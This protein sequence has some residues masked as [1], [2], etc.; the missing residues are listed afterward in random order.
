MLTEKLQRASHSR[1]HTLDGDAE[2]CGNLAVRQT[3]DAVHLE[4]LALRLGER[5]DSNPNCRGQLAGGDSCIGGGRRRR[6]TQMEFSALGGA[7]L[8]QTIEGAIARGLLEICAERSGD[9][10]TLAAPP[11]LEQHILRDFLTECTF[12]QQ[13]SRGEDE[14]GIV[15]S[16]NRVEGVLV[17][18]AQSRQELQFVHV[19]RMRGPPHCA[20]AECNLLRVRRP[21]VGL[22]TWRGVRRP[23]SVSLS[24]ADQDRPRTG[25]ANDEWEMVARFLA[26]ELSA[27]EASAFAARL[28]SD[29]SRAALVSALDDALRPPALVAPSSLDVDAALRSVRAR[30][31][32]IDSAVAAEA[33]VFKL[34]NYGRR[35]QSAGLRAAAA[36]VLVAGGAL[37]WRSASESRATE[38]ATASAPEQSAYATGV[39]TLDSLTLPDGS[40]VLLGP[41]SVLT[42]SAFAG[43]SREVTL[44]G[45]AR[46]SV[47][48]DAAHP[49][50]VHAGSASIRDVGTVFTVHSDRGHMVRVAVVE[51]TVAVRTSS[52]SAESTLHAGDRATIEVGGR[53]HAERAALSGDDLAW[54]TGQLVFRDAPVSQIAADLRRWFGIELRVDPSLAT[55]RLTATFDRSASGQIG[56]VIAAA[57]GG[58]V[59]VT[60]DTVRIRSAGAPPRR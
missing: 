53:I 27:A 24:M 59:E 54:T 56:S 8:A 35:W 42:V 41:G 37:V 29:P 36:V 47:V 11:Q 57:L 23:S 6:R 15:F 39:G 46:F 1:F 21:L 32:D 51:G 18:G 12:V 44:D 43:G 40:R 3:A 5:R 22:V 34:A 2:R 31:A 26:G 19:G 49:F 28:A 48:H 58:R 50:V 20:G 17:A 16:K 38:P 30:S 45:E 55:R 14:S 7:T 4:D 13:P 10:E 60:A 9:R 25:E 52:D 33:S